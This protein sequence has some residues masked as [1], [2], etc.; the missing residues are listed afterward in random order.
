[1][2]IAKFASFSLDKFSSSTECKKPHFSTSSRFWEKGG[3]GEKKRKKNKR[4][5]YN[6]SPGVEVIMEIGP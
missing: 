3:G 2:K 6:T 4:Q 5:D 1:M